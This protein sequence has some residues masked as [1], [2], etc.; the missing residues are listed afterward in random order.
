MENKQNFQ[1]K[2]KVIKEK[3]ATIGAIFNHNFYDEDHLDCFWYD[4]N[5]IATIEYKGYTICF[6][7]CG[8]ICVAF[9][10][11]NNFIRGWKR[12]NGSRPF[13]E[14]SECRDVIPDDT[15]LSEKAK[16]GDLIFENNNWINIVVIKE[17]NDT[18][19]NISEPEVAGES[20]LLE[21]VEN[22]FN[23][24][25]GYITDLIKN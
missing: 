8:D 13:F 3:C 25:V 10:D 11:G 1:E 22:N 24:Y 14:D 20:N 15:V 7:V 18:W 2:I 5:S 19:D 4:G 17:H 12:K 21:A 23:Y 9:Y 16:S 6:D